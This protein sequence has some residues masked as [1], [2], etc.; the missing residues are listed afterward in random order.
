M[1]VAMFAQCLL[2]LWPTSTQDQ[3]KDKF[4][5][6]ISPA[7]FS[8]SDIDLERSVL[9]AKLAEL[10]VLKMGFRFLLVIYWRWVTLC[11]VFSQL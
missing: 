7:W 6:E 9:Q 3:I 11:F 8:Q 10:V 4:R 2:Q 1:F 5:E